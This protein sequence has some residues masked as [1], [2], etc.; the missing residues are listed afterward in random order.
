MPSKKRKSTGA[1]KKKVPVK[2]SRETEQPEQQNEQDEKKIQKEEKVLVH[3]GRNE[4]MTTRSG[5]ATKQEQKPFQIPLPLTRHLQLALPASKEKTNESRTL[6]YL[7]Q[8]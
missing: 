6:L 1:R 4:G 2:K 7:N 3:E 8:C 5:S